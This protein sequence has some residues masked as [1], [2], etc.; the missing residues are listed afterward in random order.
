MR[1][2]D[3]WGL[4]VCAISAL[5]VYSWLFD[6]PMFRAP[7]AGAISIKLNTAIAF[8]WTGLAI[9]AL[10]RRRRIVRLL[11]ILIGSLAAINA[12]EY[13][14]DRPLIDELIVMDMDG[15]TIK[16]GRMAPL[17]TVGFMLV[18]L[19]LWNLG[20]CSWRSLRFSMRLSAFVSCIGVMGLLGYATHGDVLYAP[21]PGFDGMALTTSVMFV[22]AGIA[23]LEAAIN[24]AVRVF[25]G[26]V[27]TSGQV[28]HE[29]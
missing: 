9:L 29:R 26:Q 16:P 3:I 20:D 21:L 18:S 11:A 7:L 10:D 28:A 25:S 22:M 13:M 27:V 6:H 17:T 2:S 24:C 12:L 19:S 14:T 15:S 5:V 4:I 1:A 23:Q 8:L